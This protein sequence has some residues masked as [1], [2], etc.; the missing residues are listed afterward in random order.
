ML[1]SLAF[2]EFIEE[3]LLMANMVTG[4]ELRDAVKQ[5]TFIKGGDA[6]SVEGVKYDFHLGSRILMAG[7]S[8]V[9]TSLLT[10]LEKS[11]LQIGPGEVVFALSEEQLELPNDMFAQLSPKR[12]I[13]HAGVLTIG[14]FCVDPG[15]EGYLLLGLYNFSSTPFKLMP[16]KKVV[17][18][19]FHRLDASE[20]ISPGKAPEPLKEF[21]HDL[22]QTMEKYKPEGPGV[23]LETIKRIESDLN[24]LRAEVNK[25]DRFEEILTRHDS[26]IEKL[27]N[28]L[29]V[30]ADARKSGDD[31]LIRTV[32]KM[33]QT[34]GRFVTI[35][36]WLAGIATAVLIAWVLKILGLV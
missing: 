27:L 21:P 12:K 1:G 28:G 4:E 32:D 6:D 3:G 16:G 34:L 2:A 23:F 24:S 36:R 25:H 5:Q 7:G 18:A 19:T 20:A 22:V 15:Y 33:D 11:K 31:N 10:E 14:G 26:Q 9:D 35:G 29:T 13:S 30:E 17:A 8:P